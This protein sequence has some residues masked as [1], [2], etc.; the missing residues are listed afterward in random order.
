[1]NASILASG[2]KAG[3]TTESVK[4]VSW[5]HSERAPVR[6]TLQRYSSSPPSNNKRTP[7]AE[8][9]TARIVRGR[10]TVDGTFSEPKAANAGRRGSVPFQALEIGQYVSRVLI[11]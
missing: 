5:T 10:M 9:A 11:T 4:L 1:M 8:P 2:D 3:D 7:I 6:E